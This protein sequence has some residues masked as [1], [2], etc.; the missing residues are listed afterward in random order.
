M[1]ARSRILTSGHYGW[2]TLA[3]AAFVIYGSLV[4]LHFHQR[5][6]AEGWHHFRW[7]MSQPIN[8]D[9]RSDW[10][11]NILLFIPL[12]FLAIGWLTVDRGRRYWPV[13]IILPCCTILSATLELTQCWFPPR[14]T[15]VDDVV[16]ETIG[17]FIGICA[18]FACGQR[19]TEFLRHFW[20]NY[21]CHNWSMRLIPI[22]L[23]VLFFIHGM[24][25]DLTLSPANLKAKYRD[26]MILPVPFTVLDGQPL[27]L[28][29]KAIINTVWFLPAGILIVGLH[30]RWLRS[31]NAPWKVLS[32]GFVLAATVEMMQLLVMS[33]YFDSTDIITGGLA[34][35]AGW[36]LLLAWRS[37]R[38]TP[39]GIAASARW[40]FVLVPLWV[41]ALVFV[42]WEP[43]DFRFGKG[44][45]EH[46]WRNL[47]LFPFAEYYQLSYLEAANE[48]IQKT[49]L[50]VPFGLLLSATS[51]GRRDVPFVLAAAAVLAVILDIGEI[52]LRNAH[53]RMA[54]I[55]IEPFGAWLGCLSA[56]RVRR[57]AVPLHRHHGELHA[58][59]RIGIA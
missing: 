51:A 28:L 1:L 11:A 6:F 58:E 56:D 33:R 32:I 40:R 49:L 25:F 46:R 16:A 34:V 8:F 21:A 14:N 4:P 15:D 23:A 18:W 17:G 48:M 52:F 7:C 13:L 45:V 37:S 47:N 39:E 20:N 10:L 29:K 19:L 57:L 12:S 43:F 41:A 59:H 55:L 35:L 9:Q 42:H 31:S 54:D 53:P 38:E 22:Y 24:P 44:F 26:K 2:L 5:S 3:F 27:D 36:R 30:L 50:F